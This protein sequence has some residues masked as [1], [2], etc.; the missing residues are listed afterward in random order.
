MTTGF[1]VRPNATD[2][3]DPVAFETF[4]L[5]TTTAGGRVAG[6]I[7]TWNGSS[8]IAPPNTA[9]GAGGIT[10][11]T[12]DGTAGPGSGSQVLT[13]ANTAVTPGAYT[14]TDLTVDSKGRITAAASGG[15]GGGG[16]TQLTGD[17]TAGP[18]SGSQAATLANT[19]VTPGSYTSANIT[20]DSKG[21]LT[22]A[23]NGSGGGGSVV[24]QTVQTSTT[25]F[26]S[27]GTNIPVDNTIPQNT[28]GA[29][30]LTLAITPQNAANIIEI[31][32]SGYGSAD[33]ATY[34][35]VAAFVDSTAD[36]LIANNRYFTQSNITAQINLRHR[37]TAGSTSART[38]KIRYG[39]SGGTAYVNGASLAGALFGG[40]S[41]AILS[42]TEYTQ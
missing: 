7:Y 15:G 38:Y 16:I 35:T 13:L 5:Q 21:R 11:L 12:G 40:V 29:E 41:R 14:A 34:Y 3:T 27:T 37:L 31:E 42:L 32:F 22:A 33:G 9:G 20:V 4:V 2:I 36:A 17:V 28:E 18:G 6:G 24:V 26:T 30:L 25:T 1:L 10:Q 23:A 19:A 8:W 39:S